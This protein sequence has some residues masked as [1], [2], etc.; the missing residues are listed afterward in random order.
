MNDDIRKFGTGLGERVIACPGRC[1]LGM[2]E[3]EKTHIGGNSGMM[4]K[5]LH[6][7]VDA[8]SDHVRPAS[9]LVTDQNRRF[10]MRLVLECSGERAEQLVFDEFADVWMAVAQT[11]AGLRVGYWDQGRILRLQLCR[12]QHNQR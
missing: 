10:W 4:A 11:D 2:R 12:V 6:S 3:P 1:A 8:W 9:G 5:E 7:P